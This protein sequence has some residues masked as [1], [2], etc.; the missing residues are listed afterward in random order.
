MLWHLN[1]LQLYKVT[2]PLSNKEF[3]YTLSILRILFLFNIVS[4]LANINTVNLCMNA[5]NNDDSDAPAL[6][7]IRQISNTNLTSDWLQYLPPYLGALS[8][9]S[10]PN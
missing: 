2:Q 3:D 8:A 10:W 4:D 5:N 7:M 6:L 9:V 1:Y